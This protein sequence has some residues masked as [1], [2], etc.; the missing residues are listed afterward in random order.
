MRENWTECDK[1]PAKLCL[2]YQAAAPAAAERADEL[3]ELRFRH[4]MD[5]KSHTRI[6]SVRNCQRVLN[7]TRRQC[8]RKNQT[9]GGGGRGDQQQA[10]C[11]PGE[12][13][14]RGRI[15]GRTQGDRLRKLSEISSKKRAGKS[16]L[17]WCE[18]I[19]LTDWLST[20]GRRFLIWGKK[21]RTNDVSHLPR[22]RQKKYLINLLSAE[23]TLVHTL[24]FN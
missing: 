19:R 24:G 16:C 8:R 12:K 18:F 15:I 1:P 5:A 10:D 3:C 11:C 6:H 2:I 4:W 17:L 7:F 23:I 20:S 13:D 21:G 22:N 14:C 9:A